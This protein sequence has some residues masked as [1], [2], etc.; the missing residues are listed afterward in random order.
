M[1]KAAAPALYLLLA[2][3]DAGDAVSPIPDPSDPSLFLFLR[4]DKVLDGDTLLVAGK[5]IRI[6]GIDAPELGPW[7]RCWAEAALAGHAKFYVETELSQ[8][9]WR[10]HDVSKPDAAGRRTARLVRNDRD[11]LADLLEVGGYA[12]V[13]AARW[14]WCGANANLHSPTQDEPAPHGPNLWWP[15]GRVFD[16]RASD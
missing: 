8:G 5:P 7:A 12:A 1:L 16:A 9:R 15:S 6:A 2:A 13:T 10:V 3:C 14:D 11:D 4:G